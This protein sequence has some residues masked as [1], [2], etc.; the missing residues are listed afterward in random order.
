MKLIILC[1]DSANKP[2]PISEGVTEIRINSQSCKGIN[3]NRR[4]T[5]ASR[6]PRVAIVHNVIKNPD[7]ILPRPS[8][9]F[10]TY[11]LVDTPWVAQTLSHSTP[12]KRGKVLSN[13]SIH[14]ATQFGDFIGP[15]CVNTFEMLV[16]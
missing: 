7:W 12:V 16:H 15:V 6:A 1:L 14:E 3:L 13:S 10:H 9:V 5:Q 11:A 4:H 8:V 2:S